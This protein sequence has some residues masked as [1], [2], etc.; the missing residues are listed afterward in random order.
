MLWS[1]GCEAL[2]AGD[3][4][5]FIGFIRGSPCSGKYPEIVVKLTL[6]ILRES[7]KIIGFV[8]VFERA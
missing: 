5:T 8:L 4:F 2:K 1:Y 6:H 7:A 3:N